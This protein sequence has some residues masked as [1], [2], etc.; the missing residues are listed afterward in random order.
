MASLN[1]SGASSI[2]ASC[3]NSTRDEAYDDLR[4]I[5][6]VVMTRIQEIIKIFDEIKVRGEEGEEQ[7]DASLR[8]LSYNEARE[9]V[10]DELKKWY[11]KS[12]LTI[13]ERPG[14]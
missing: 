10:I 12:G 9:E 1:I 7:L 8:R 11:A 6:A 2:N 3:F 5:Q 13:R 14:N 4:V